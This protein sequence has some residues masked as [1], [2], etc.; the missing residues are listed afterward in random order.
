MTDPELIQTLD[1]ILNRSDASSLE[2]LAQAVMR[3][4]RDLSIFNVLGGRPNPQKAAKEISEKINDGIGAGIEGMRKSIQEMIVKVLR[5]NAPELNEKQINELCMAWMPETPKKD[6]AMPQGALLSMIEQ[7]ISFSRGEMKESVDKNLR[8]EMGAWPKR[9][10]NAFPPVV[11]GVI[12]D[13]LKDKISEQDF[14]S[15]IVIALGL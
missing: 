8:E 4:R 5:E 1:Y 13:F 9:Y 3:R 7:F 6:A 15:R 2:V 14:K 11:R 10:W 12:T